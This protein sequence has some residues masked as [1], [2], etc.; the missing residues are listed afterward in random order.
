MHIPTI[1][2]DYE[3]RMKEIL[4]KF[5]KDYDLHVDDPEKFYDLL[6]SEYAE[7]FGKAVL[8][9]MWDFSGEEL[10]EIEREE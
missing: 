9:D 1:E 4:E 6:W 10:F 8:N 2:E 5:I 7:E 3:Y